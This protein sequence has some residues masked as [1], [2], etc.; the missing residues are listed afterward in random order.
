MNPEPSWDPLG[1]TAELPLRETFYP[2]GFSLQIET[3]CQDVLASAR[4]SWPGPT[5]R[6]PDSPLRIRIIVSGV[7]QDDSSLPAPSA[8]AQGHLLTLVAGR[9]D[10]AACDAERG[11]G[12]AVVRGATARDSRHFRFYYLE[13]LAYALL[14]WHCVTAIH[15]SCVS[16]GESA[17]LFCGK[18]GAGKSCLA[19]ACVRGGLEFVSDDAVYLVRGDSTRMVLGKPQWLRL[20]QSAV[21]LFPEF[22]AYP[23]A[24][25]VNGEKVI[26]LGTAQMSGVTTRETAQKARVVFVERRSEAASPRL[27]RVGPEEALQ[28][29]VRELPRWEARI[30]GE[31]VDSVRQMVAGGAHRL[32]YSDLAPAVEKVKHLLAQV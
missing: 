17:V 13:C 29:L 24:L 7:G 18:S 8:H 1:Y 12:F 6:F 26:E 22:R 15:A 2:L 23:P 14:S 25:D 5:A 9:N 10:F 21:E 28:L 11:F 32:I 27:E 16:A 30:S 3:N 20:K 19:Y 4:L 31:Q